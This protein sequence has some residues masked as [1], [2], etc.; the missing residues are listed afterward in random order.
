MNAE[1]LNS[2]GVSVSLLLLPVTLSFVIGADNLFSF[3]SPG[4]VEPFGG[5]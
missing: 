5:S 3:N 1:L 2:F 4:I